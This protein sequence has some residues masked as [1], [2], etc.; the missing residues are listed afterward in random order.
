MLYT[1]CHSEVRVNM[2][3]SNFAVKLLI[4]HDPHIPGITWGSISCCPCRSVASAEDDD[5][6]ALDSVPVA[7]VRRDFSTKTTPIKASPKS[8]AKLGKDDQEL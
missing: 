6:H 7:F 8:I 5:F 4:P 2:N 3:N 1:R